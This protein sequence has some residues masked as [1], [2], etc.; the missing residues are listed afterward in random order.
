VP[1][2]L[3]RIAFINLP[4]VQ[5]AC[6]LCFILFIL[7][8]QLLFGE[9]YKFEENKGQW[10]TNIKYRCE[11]IGGWLYFEKNTFTYLF[12]DDE[13]I[14]HPHKNENHIDEEP[15]VKFHSLKAHFI[16][17]YASPIFKAEKPYSFYKNYFI[18]NDSSTW[19]SNIKSY[20]KLN[21][22]NL[23]P[24]I[25]LDIYTQEQFLKYDI[26]ANP[27]SNIQQIQIKYE[28][29]DKIYLNEGNLMVHT[30]LA[31]VCEQKPM[32]YQII[33]GQKI[34]IACQ[35]KLNNDMVS[36]DFP[37]GYDSTQAL[38]I[39]PVLIVSTYTGSTADNWGYTATYDKNGNI[40]TGGIAAD[41]GYPTSTGAYQTNFSG[42]GGSY[43][44]DVVVS[45]FNS[46]GTSLL[47][48]TYLGGSDNE[49]PHSLVVN[50]NE[51]LYILGETYSNGFPVKAGCYDGT[52]N[53]GADIFVSK[54][55]SNFTSLLSSTFI[56][57]TADDGVNVSSDSYTYQTTKYN[58]GDDARSE[59]ILDDNSNVYVASCASSIT[60]PVTS[61]AYQ[62]AKAGDQ[63]GVVF[64]MDAGLSTLIWSTY[65]GGSKDDA[66][67]GL[68]LDA[69]K[70]V[71]VTGGTASSD[72]PV[73]AGAYKVLF[74]GGIADGFITKL[75]SNGGSLL[76]STFIGTSKYDQSFMIQSDYNGDVYV[77]GQ[78][79][80]S[81]PVSAGV[82]SNSGGKQFIHKLSS[83]LSTSV[84][85]TVFGS[86]STYPDI[87]PT[88]FLVDTCLNV[89][90]TG[91]GNCLYGSTSG[92]TKGMVT[93]SNAQQTY[94]DGCDFY[95][96]VLSSN[97]ASL[98]YATYFGDQ[99][100]EDHVDGG[101][102]RFDKSGVI[103][104]SVCASCGG[105]NG[106]PTTSSAY[107][108]T[109]NSYNCNNAVIKMDFQFAGLNASAVPSPN[110]TLCLGEAISFSNTSTNGNSYEWD[111]GDGSNILVTTTPPSHSYTNAGTYSVKL[112]ATN[113]NS[114]VYSDTALIEITVLPLPF[115]DLG[116]DTV[117]CENETLKLNPQTSSATYYNWSTGE[118][119]S[120]ITIS[121]EGNYWL[122]V[123]NGVCS[124]SDS[125]EINI[126]EKPYL[127]SDT[128]VC[129]GSILELDAM[130]TGAAYLWST[131]K[132]TQTINATQSGTYWVDV[133][134]GTCVE[135]DTIVVNM[136]PE[137]IVD[138]GEDTVICLGTT[139]NL[140]APFDPL[141]TYLW[142]TGETSSSITIDEPSTYNVTVYYY[143]C[144]SADELSIELKNPVNLGSDIS[145]CHQPE[146]II[147]ATVN[148]LNISYSWST[149]ES[150]SSITVYEPGTYWVDLT[151]Y[152]C[153]YSDTIEVI[154]HY[155][156]GDIYTPNSFTPVNQDGLNDI[157]LARGM[158][159]TEFKLQIF[160]RWGNFI[161]SSD[162]LNVGWDGTI[163]GTKVKQGV[164]VWLIDY[165]NICTEDKIIHKIGHIALF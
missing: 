89:Y 111:F 14:K 9:G 88:A 61:G 10:H 143:N 7:S 73:S 78:T 1:H 101:T 92:S 68:I 141:Y 67:F 44:F 13:T 103:Y 133:L 106:F 100:A 52:Y 118:T 30:S 147:S 154:G 53:S 48:S 142:N 79:E 119:N 8:N 49:S 114:C 125:I 5:N 75:S 122:K 155:L 124:A 15:I 66:A 62:L 153:T 51:E 20:E 28:G 104:Q 12:Y 26:I 131:G 72:F 163:N 17:A 157:F 94:T 96:F 81:Y 105:S 77:Y 162:D 90:C 86:G 112:L 37:G 6:C 121:K 83:D 145:L 59:I 31:S 29:A 34:E 39:D 159:V 102:S 116:N 27:Y 150:D 82:Y 24:G 123:S 40:Y 45:K 99:N 3:F 95:F 128:T 115:V 80:G 16:G 4:F 74:N 33:N 54:F 87:S 58:Y 139:I 160:D 97:A 98:L 63:D 57:G 109:N 149:G 110:D 47:S 11:L 151:H 108:T 38:V 25:D 76:Y 140:Q 43:P 55:N 161:F 144:S 164:Y 93:T 152:Q 21:Y 129:E 132:T 136:M 85:S 137:P 18:G 130:N 126:I 41:Y 156:A 70:N 113:I 127:G 2:Y 165:K 19:K 135:T 158:D 71:Y 146:A 138:L 23:Y 35:F 64:K 117:I 60:F 69:S 32:A 22:Q 91:W 56:G 134:G 107:S 120:S 84:W 65:L 50:D 36:F 42:G 148:E 46:N